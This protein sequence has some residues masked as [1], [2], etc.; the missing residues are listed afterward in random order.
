MSIVFGS[1]F[2]FDSAIADP[3]AQKA[4]TGHESGDLKAMRSKPISSMQ[5]SGAMMKER[6]GDNTFFVTGVVSIIFR[7]VAPIAVVIQIA[8]T[9]IQ[10]I[11][12]KKP[13]EK[14]RI[15]HKIAPIIM[16]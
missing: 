9:R 1:G 16:S 10:A 11:N 6:N 13:G 2:L 7:N 4:N 8:G 5:K 12:R 3:I 14:K 15:E